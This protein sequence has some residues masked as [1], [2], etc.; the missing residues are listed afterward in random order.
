MNGLVSYPSDPQAEQLAVMTEEMGESSQVIGKIGRHGLD[1]R[2]P[3]GGPTNAGL[4]ETELGHV[5]AAMDLLIEAKTVNGAAIASARRAKL[6]S[7][8]RWLHCEQNIEHARAVANQLDASWSIE[9]ARSML[10]DARERFR[11]AAL[12]MLTGQETDVVALAWSLQNAIGEMSVDEALDALRSRI[13][14]GR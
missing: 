7:I 13:A 12:E 10:A 3:N 5:M 1:S 11:R 14:Q 8:Q 9:S 6:S 2:H 4:L